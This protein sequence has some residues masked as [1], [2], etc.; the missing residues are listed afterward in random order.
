[1]TVDNEVKKIVLT[2]LAETDKEARKRAIGGLT[3]RVGWLASGKFGVWDK[4]RTTTIEEVKSELRHV[5]SMAYVKALFAEHPMFATEREKA[6][7]TKKTGL[8]PSKTNIDAL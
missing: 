1:M 3:Y 6:H 2:I 4:F 5:K 8:K 7:L